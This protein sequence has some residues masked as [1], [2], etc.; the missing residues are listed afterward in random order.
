M[1]GYAVQASS[2]LL[3]NVLKALVLSG[4]AFHAASPH[5][6]VPSCH[7]GYCQCQIAA[8]SVSILWLQHSLLT[9]AVEITLDTASDNVLVTHGFLC[10]RAAQP[11]KVCCDGKAVGSCPSVLLY[12]TAATCFAG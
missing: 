12:V 3:V 5:R 11:A 4:G 2:I 1:Q 8:L 9:H 6:I 7:L 10:G